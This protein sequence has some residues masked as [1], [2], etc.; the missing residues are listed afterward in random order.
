MMRG[1][2]QSIMY[3]L[4]RSKRGD[5]SQFEEAEKLLAFNKDYSCLFGLIMKSILVKSMANT[6]G[7]GAGKDEG[8]DFY[9]KVEQEFPF[10][11]KEEV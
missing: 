1:V 5:I 8:K 9:A 6:T 7:S 3:R 10:V 2:F 11:T 4:F